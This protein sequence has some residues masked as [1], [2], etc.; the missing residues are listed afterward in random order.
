MEKLQNLINNELCFAKNNQFI[1]N[2]EPA[3]GKVYSQIPRSD[4]EDVEA[5]IESA[6]K[7]FSVWSMTSLEERSQILLKIA[8]GIEARLEEFAK[9]ESKDN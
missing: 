3:T 6:K 9:A 1:D 8:D 4:K 5:A 7:A 2:F